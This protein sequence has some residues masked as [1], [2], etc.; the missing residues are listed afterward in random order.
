VQILHGP[1]LIL[2]GHFQQP[3]DAGKNTIYR[4]MW[5]LKVSMQNESGPEGYLHFCELDVTPSFYCVKAL[6][7]CINGRKEASENCSKKMMSK[8]RNVKLGIASQLQ[9]AK[10]VS[11]SVFV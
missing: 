7:V 4:N 11:F 3:Y 2:H 8:V 9:S 6:P 1:A 10:I 5:L